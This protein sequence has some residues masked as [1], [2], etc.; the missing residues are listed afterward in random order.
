MAAMSNPGFRMRRRDLLLGLLALPTA[1]QAQSRPLR[2]GLLVSSEPPAKVVSAMRE[3]LGQA[4]YARGPDLVIDMQWPTPSQPLPALAAKMVRDA[5]DIIVAWA[6]PAALAVKAATTTIPVVIVGIA[7]PVGVGLVA[8]LAHPGGN[9]TGFSNLGGDLS[10][11]EVEV[12]VQAVPRPRRLGVIYNAAS[13]AGVLQFQGVQ[14]ALQKLNVPALVDKAAQAAEYRDALARLG[15]ATVDGVL[16]VPDAATI[17]NR[18]AIAAQAQSLKLPTMFQ[19]RENVEAGG[20]MS[21][22]PDLADQFRQVGSYID[23]I[24]KGAKP[25]DLPV[26]QPDKIELVINART[27]RAIGISLPKML[28]GRADEVLE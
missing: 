18:A 14:V 13:P 26:Q 22:G 10:A 4:G 21:Y 6:T 3:S 11:K 12:F 5:P 1:A 25:A 19:R 20:L 8:S 9:I 15:Q 17:E 28:L 16:F 23:R 27:A 24:L 2:I 7:D